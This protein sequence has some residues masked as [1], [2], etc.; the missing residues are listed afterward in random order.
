M[1]DCVI[2]ARDLGIEKDELQLCLWYLH[3]CTGTIMYYPNIPG[4]Y[5]RGHVICTPQVVF[6][7]ISEFI[8]ASMRILHGDGVVIESERIELIKKG[9][10][11]IKSI[12][13]YSECPQVKEKLKERK[14]L[15]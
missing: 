3:H 13:K 14:L 10:F 5:F 11:S 6:D 15:F 9:Q 7:S 4:K 2:I 8:V 12:E 1:G